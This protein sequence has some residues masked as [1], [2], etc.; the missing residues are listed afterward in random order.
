MN[1]SFLKSSISL[2]CLIL[3]AMAFGTSQADFSSLEGKCGAELKQAIKALA[4]PHKVISYGDA[5]WEAFMQTDVREI[6]GN[7]AWFDMYSNRLVYVENGH[8]G[9]NIEHSVA[10][11]WWGGTRND[12]YKDLYHL[13]PSDADAN[14]R[15]NNNPLGVISGRPSWSNGLTRI[16]TPT[17]VTGGGASTVFEPAD[18]YKGDFARAYFYIFTVYDDIAWQTS[19]AYMYD[20]SEWPTLLPWATDMLLE[21][22]AADPVDAREIAR[23]RAVAGVQEN[24]NPYIE[25]PV[26][27]EYVWGEKKDCP[28]VYE[29]PVYAPARPEA[30]VFNNGEMQYD[31]AGVNTWSG[32]W[33]QPFSLTLSA[34]EGVIYYTLTDS[35]DY[36]LYDSAIG[37]GAASASGETIQVRSYAETTYNGRPYR[38]PVS[39]LTLTARNTGA[40]DYMFAEWEKVTD[41][42][43]INSENIYVVTGC[44]TPVVMTCEGKST[45]SSKYIAAADNV[46][47]EDGKIIRLP[48]QAALVKLLP[49]GGGQWYLSLSNIALEEKGC[50]YTTMARQMTISAQGAPAS[51]RILPDKRTEINFGETLG[52]LQYNTTSPRFLNYT[53]SQQGINLYYCTDNGQTGI[54][55]PEIESIEE[56]W[57]QSGQTLLYNLN[58]VIVDEGSACAGLYIK[59]TNLGKG[60]KKYEKIMICR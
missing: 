4:V 48:E 29:D 45:S 41:M 20:E 60:G 57:P 9:M 21:W 38:S 24:L 36:Q 52:I 39:T 27:A 25:L 31:I 34:P 32:R 30:P 53:S 44:Q 6:A 2:W 5:T 59:V 3:P 35:D 16:G 42:S 55:A 14:N 28:Y 33:W 22:A 1:I 10:N 56:T 47:M 51:I 12:A 11:S 43:Q 54:S 50:L 13:N 58:G 7:L 49:A 46:V 40:T 8:G 19:P 18:E 26:L 15:K 23:A 37:I 17:S